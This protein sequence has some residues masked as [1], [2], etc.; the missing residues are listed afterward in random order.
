M[1][2]NSFAQWTS[3]QPD[4]FRIYSPVFA[5][6]EVVFAVS[7]GYNLYTSENGG[8]SYE[9]KSFSAANNIQIHCFGRQGAFY[10]AG[11]DSGVYRSEN[12]G[13][14][15]T[16]VRTGLPVGFNNRIVGIVASGDALVAISYE[17]GV[18]RS[19]DNGTSWVASTTGMSGVFYEWGRGLAWFKGAI[20][21]ATVSG[22]F[23]SVDGGLNWT[24]S[25][26]TGMNGITAGENAIFTFD[27]T[28]IARS[29]D[30]ETWEG[31]GVGVSLSTSSLI[32]SAVT[33]YKNTVFA[34][35]SYINPN[36]IS[37]TGVFWSKNGGASFE[38]IQDNMP[39]GEGARSIAVNDSSIFV[40]VS[41]YIFTRRY[42]PLHALPNESQ[43]P[44]AFS[45]RQ[46]Y[47][48]PFNP[49]TTIPFSLKETGPVK[50]SVF[51]LNGRIVGIPVNGIRQAGEHYV[52]F[53]ASL[54]SSGIYYYMLDAGGRS[55][56][57][58]MTLIK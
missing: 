42:A 44:A 46:N 29:S 51:D 54:L 16:P 24:L 48:N 49:S 36:R 58:K 8:Q 14:T 27:Y 28:S 41:D 10:F 2:R 15:W 18:F 39:S 6:E 3:L 50:L 37:D 53:D 7:N 47:P 5:T 32:I 52:S 13:N 31:G 57:G 23:K 12:R 21:A 17:K 38:S 56:A 30:G 20:Y 34:G 26:G 25:F 55:L 22:V 4:G 45:L 11:T 40:G 43:K 1:C 9:Q 33:A 19:V 35:T